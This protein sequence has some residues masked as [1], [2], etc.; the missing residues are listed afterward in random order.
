MNK[1][2]NTI[3]RNI[4]KGIDDLFDRFADNPE[5]AAMT[6]EQAVTAA[7]TRSISR[8]GNLYNRR[9][10]SGDNP[11]TLVD[12]TM[13]EFENSSVSEKMRQQTGMETSKEVEKHLIK[14]IY[15]NTQR[16]LKEAGIDDDDYVTVY[17]GVTFNRDKDGN[18]Y[19]EGESYNI[20]SNPLESWT[21]ST[22]IARDFSEG[23]GVI[24]QARVP[25]KRIFSTMATGSGCANEFEVIVIGGGKEDKVTI[26]KNRNIMPDDI[27]FDGSI[28]DY[29]YDEE[30]IAF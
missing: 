7:I 11:F 13:Q 20:E 10:F 17:R 19:N 29:N 25:R 5:V 4:N 24:L 14:T 2:N 8:N 30:E 12:D 18:L 27:P 21:L 3:N 6:R 15:N 26:F 23:S 9:I 16:Q 1:K 22:S 28:P